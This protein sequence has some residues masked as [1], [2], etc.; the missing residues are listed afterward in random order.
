MCSAIVLVS[1]CM[2][3]RIRVRTV[4]VQNSHTHLQHSHLLLSLILFSVDKSS[5]LTVD[6]GHDR[7][8]LVRTSHTHGGEGA[9]K[10]TNK[11]HF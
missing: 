11:C 2:N 10:K 6:G 5:F 8:V 9:A 4:C 1:I 7:I 3:T